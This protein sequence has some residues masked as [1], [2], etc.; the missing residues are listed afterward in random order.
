MK[1]SV[2]TPVYNAEN[3]I[4]ELI[5][6]VSTELQL[7]TNNFEINKGQIGSGNTQYIGYT[8]EERQLYKDQ[9]K[10]LLEE[11]AYLKL[12]IDKFKMQ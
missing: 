10:H 1:I 5:K 9:I 2:V 8:E 7:I 6:R 12:L 4:E 3:I 11:N